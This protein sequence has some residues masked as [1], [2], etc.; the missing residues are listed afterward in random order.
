MNSTPCFILHMFIS[1]ATWWRWFVIF[2]V[3][4]CG[5]FNLSHWWFCLCQTRGTKQ[6]TTYCI[7]WENLGTKKWRTCMYGCFFLLFWVLLHFSYKNFFYSKLS[8]AIHGF[9]CHPGNWIYGIFCSYQIKMSFYCNTAWCFFLLLS[10][11]L[12][13]EV[14]W[15]IVVFV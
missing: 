11:F 6:A 5:G 2:T 9:L 10:I 15:N 1:T 4:V 7:H 3:T 13:L 12:P 14:V 8:I